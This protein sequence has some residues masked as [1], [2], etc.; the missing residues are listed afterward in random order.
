MPDLIVY[1]E[2]NGFHP[3]TSDIEAILR[4]CDHDADRAFSF[5]EFNELIDLPSQEDDIVEDNGIVLITND[6]SPIRK[7][8]SESVKTQSLRKRR[9]SN[10]LDNAPKEN[11]DESWERKE[12]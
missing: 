2:D 8:L 7:D 10:D 11:I 9:N 12:A 6:G 4:R 1:L 5:E 3:R